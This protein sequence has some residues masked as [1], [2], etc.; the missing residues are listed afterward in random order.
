MPDK[1]FFKCLSVVVLCNGI[2]LT[3]ERRNKMI[4]S[5]VSLF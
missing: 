5:V 1:L 3:M 2:F 4:I